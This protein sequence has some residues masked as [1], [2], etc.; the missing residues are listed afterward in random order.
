MDQ[1]IVDYILRAQ[2][3]GLAEQEIK[4][5]LL[6][7]GWDAGIVEQNFIYARAADTHS[8]AD[9]TPSFAAGYLYSQNQNLSRQPAPFQSTH[10]AISISEQNFQSKL[11]AKP[12]F[13]NK[14]FWIVLAL[15]AVLGA[16]ALGYY[17]YVYA[18]PKTVFNKFLA[19]KRPMVFTSDYSLSYSYTDAS[20]TKPVILTFSGTLYHNGQNAGGSESGNTFTLGLKSPVANAGVNLQYLLINNVLYINISQISQLKSLGSDWVKLDLGQIQNYLDPHSTTTG[21][22]LS[23]LMSSPALKTKLQNLMAN[24]KIVDLSNFLT[25]ETIKGI[26]VYHLKIILDSQALASAAV[27]AIDLIQND[28]GFKGQKIT[29]V[30]KNEIGS[31]LKKLNLKE[32]D[33]WIGQK[34]YQLYQAH[35]LLNAPSAQD[36]SNPKFGSAIPALGQSLEKN[37]DATRLNDSRQLQQALQLYYNDHGGYPAGKIGV[38]QGL[39]PNYISAWPVAPTPLD[40]TCTDYF[41]G[42]WYK[43]K[44]AAF[45]KNGVTLYPSFTLTF[46]LGQATGGYD[47]GIGMITPQGMAGNVACPATPD[48]CVNGKPAGSEDLQAQINGL[49]FDSALDFDGTFYNFGKTQTLQAPANSLDLMQLLQSF[50]GSIAKTGSTTQ[51]SAK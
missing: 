15:L 35:L 42:Y 38:P 13:R 44:G 18:T 19:A 34:D 41:N 5:N 11:P 45:A 40:G 7:A 28:P 50:F 24:S 20:S 32:G 3:H 46:C 31:V 21:Q 36:L 1:E 10:T 4:Q 9:Q 12:F 17:K 8:S 33:V 27:L 22:S 2:K 43:N 49:P 30:Q 23:G 25:K 51:A 47:A 29:D 14:I 37:R 6:S 16:S 26:P 48:L 39:I